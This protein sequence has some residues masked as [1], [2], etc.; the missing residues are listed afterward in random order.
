[1]SGELPMGL[2]MATIAGVSEET[3]DET[4]PS[5]DVA[6]GSGCGAGA[7]AGSAGASSPLAG[8]EAGCAAADSSGSSHKGVNWLAR[9]SASSNDSGGF[10]LGV[11]SFAD[12]ASAR[13]ADAGGKVGG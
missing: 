8:G 9:R 5:S 11:S 7:A 13:F 4:G 2:A 1:M 12:I 3:G 10:E 6:A